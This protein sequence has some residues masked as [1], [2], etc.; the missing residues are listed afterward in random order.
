MVGIRLGVFN[1]AANRI[2]L[3]A[4]QLPFKASHPG[5]LGSL[6]V[7]LIIYTLE[8]CKFE[9]KWYLLKMLSYP[10]EIVLLFFIGMEG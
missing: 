7:G 5:L 9:E 8:H 2:Q 3:R 1:P 10:N 6:K 4:S